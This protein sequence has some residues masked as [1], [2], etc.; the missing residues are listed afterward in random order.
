MLELFEK[1]KPPRILVELAQPIKDEP[2][3]VKQDPLAALRA[4]TIEK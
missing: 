2:E 4:S 3:P 1:L